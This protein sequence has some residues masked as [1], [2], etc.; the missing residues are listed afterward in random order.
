MENENKNIQLIAKTDQHTIIKDIDGKE[1][2]I[3]IDIYNFLITEGFRWGQY[4]GYSKAKNIFETCINNCKSND[5]I[6]DEIPKEY[7]SKMF[8]EAMQELRKNFEDTVD[9]FIDMENQTLSALE[10]KNNNSQ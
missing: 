10:R 4:N 1:I 2:V 6:P 9:S 5:E 7:V 3:S 8:E